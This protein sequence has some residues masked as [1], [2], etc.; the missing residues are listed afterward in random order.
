LVGPEDQKLSGAEGVVSYLLLELRFLESVSLDE[1]FALGTLRLPSFP[2]DLAAFLPS[3]RKDGIFDKRSALQ[4]SALIK[5]SARPAPQ[6]AI[7]NLQ[8]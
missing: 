3:R 5:R 1:R 8:S 6:P 4:A 2:S 7:F